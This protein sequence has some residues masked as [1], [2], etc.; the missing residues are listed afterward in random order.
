[1]LSC[2]FGQPEDLLLASEPEGARSRP[3]A[4]AFAPAGSGCPGIRA[5]A[6]PGREPKLELTA[7]EA[8]VKHLKSVPQRR[9]PSTPISSSVV[10]I[11][12]SAGMPA[13]S[14]P[15][16]CCLSRGLAPGWLHPFWSHGGLSSLWQDRNWPDEPF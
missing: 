16:H 11:P 7:A 9:T 1:M 4:L 8:S 6:K 12:R 3:W 2:H 15:A 14:L 13:G 5:M 10:F